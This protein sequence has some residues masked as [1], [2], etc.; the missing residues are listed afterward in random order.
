MKRPRT[1]ATPAYGIT[2]HSRLACPAPDWASYVRYGWIGRVGMFR[3][4]SWA[5]GGRAGFGDSDYSIVVSPRARAPEHMRAHF[6]HVFP[7]RAILVAIGSLARSAH[8][9]EQ[10]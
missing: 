5:G 8:A 3:P 1:Y 4:E 2:Q 10:R 9:G 7:A 6:P